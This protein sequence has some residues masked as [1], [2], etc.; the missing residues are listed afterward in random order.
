MNDSPPLPSRLL[1]AYAFIAKWSLVTLAAFWLLVAAAWGALNG[2]ILPRIGDWRPELEMHASGA[3]GVPVRIGQVQAHL[4]GLV[5]SFELGD[6][7]LLDP[8]GREALRLQRVVVALS[9][10]SL[11][12]R[13]FDQLYV[14]GPRLDVRRAADGRLFIAGLDVSRGGTDDGAAADWLF[15]Q[16]E[17]VV[18]GG[19]VQWTDEMRQAP[20]L[21]LS[22]VDLVVRNTGRRHAIRLDATPAPGWGER[23]TL[24]GQFRHPFFGR[25]G[26]WQDWDGQ[27]HA[28]FPRVDLRELRRH[29]Q[30]GVQVDGG[31]GA[32]RAWADLA[33]GQIT[34]G[35]ADLSVAGVSATLAPALQPLALASLSGRIGG[36]R[37]P[38]GVELETRQLQFTTADGQRWPGGNVYVSW[39]DADGKKP[40]AGEL[41]A[42]R[43]DLGALR[44]LAG[45]LPLGAATHQALARHAPRG[46]VESLQAKWQGPL[47]APQKYQARGKVAGL[48]LVAVPADRL[49]GVRN[50][51]IDFE[52]TEGGGKARVAL[53]DGALELPGVFEE[54]LLPFDRFSTDLQ[55]QL[56]GAR[57]S[58]TAANLRF[59]NADAQGEAQA[60]WR[61]GDDPAHRFPGVLDLQGSLSRVKG[62]RVWRYLP[63][64][65]P[66][67]A[68]EYVR[69]SVQQ[70]DASDARFR[71]R[72]DLRHFPFLQPRQGEFR[73]TAEVRNATFAFA[74][75]RLNPGRTPWPALTQ[76]SGRLVF[77]RG[78]M[79]VEDANGRF[80]TSPNLRVRATA[81]IPELN[82]T[83]VGV[84]GEVRG[85]LNEALAVVQ[86]SPVSALIGD[87][88]GQASASGAGDV[89]LRLSLPV[90]QIDR[91]RV[92]GTVTLGGNDVQIT[93]DSPLLA[94]ARGAVTFTERGFAVLGAQARVYGGDV[95][96]EG[97]TRPVAS[98]GVVLRVQ[99]QATAEALRQAR[100]LG[101][102]S[103]LAQKM[104][105]AAGY[106]ATLTFRG[107]SPEV[108]LTSNLQGLALN[109][110]PPLNKPP[111]AVLPLKYENAVVREGRNANRLDQLVVEVGSLAAVHYL[112]DITGAEPRVLRGSLAIGLSPGE[113][114]VLP[115]QGVAANIALGTLNVDAWE[116]VLEGLDGG[117]A[118]PAPRNPDAPRPPPGSA[119]SLSYLPTTLALRA[120]E[121]TMDGRTL[122]NLV[123]GGSRDGLLWRGNVEADELNGYVEYRQ[124]AGAGA[125]RVHARLARLS[126]AAAAA[127]AVETLLDEQPGG[128]PALDVIVEDFELRGRKL[129]RLE[130]DAVN[131]GGG[132]VVREGGVREWR[133]NKLTLTL[134]EAVF[135]ATGNWAGADA[136]PVPPGGPRPPRL[137]AERRRTAMN[138]RLDIADSGLLLARFG[139]KDVVRRGQGR[140]EGQVG[141]I[142][143]PMSLD[144]PSMHGN[145]HVDINAGQFL[146]ADPGLAKLLGVLNLQTLPRRL[147]LDFRD[148]FSQGFGFDFVRGDV[149]IQQGIAATNNLQMK[150]I[151]AAVLMEGRADLARE[152]QDLRV[153]VVPEIN[154]GTAS[155]VAAAI[156]P[157]IGL[158]TFLAQIFLREPLARAATQQFQ[159]DGTWTDPRVTRL[160]RNE[161]RPP[162]TAG[163]DNTTT[164]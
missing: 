77:D 37:L 104:A 96:I 119:P 50:A 58:V 162:D 144:Y 86:R 70:G 90:A 18:R 43:L 110:P 75:A 158:G 9:P 83:V 22:Q 32:V 147:A 80:S 7:V 121:L 114:V 156:N 52:L 93:P 123:V 148:V 103:R 34:G 30:L 113:A 21:S 88:L 73:V 118:P 74:P 138:F 117:G 38:G 66:R 143:S 151:N 25:P 150:G 115:E 82:N 2:W 20:E 36:K 19:A 164:R 6:V 3:L 42:D 15:R 163:A 49:P 108:S 135:N 153:V 159:I 48:H 27:L 95:R 39:T 11:W 102:V 62:T 161:P 126:I 124:P 85:P 142:G 87:V 13:G 65:V 149:T 55:W 26:R 53:P 1:R 59:S 72:G 105:G 76:L 99:G 89:R 4:E 79:R 56:Q 92:Q 33:R 78:G 122:H 154:A 127:Q 17:I 137:P 63:L 152:T 145:F 84:T 8:Q 100:E 157:A 57:I 97:G 128:I 101:F 10:K 81:E 47:Q 24:V 129:G 134:P 109:L 140:M 67:D 68:R 60:T 46:L 23:F 155:L 51:A 29:A 136:Q 139:M 120:R 94:R 28:D 107:A 133:L 146:K 5:P 61:T 64:G 54:A 45:A 125:G 160:P 31:H 131:R 132:A 71:V 106:N 130:I 98:E 35:V 16:S 44:Q 41:R 40:A 111:D 141:W 12:N 116:Q 91:S 112:R 14:E 69:E